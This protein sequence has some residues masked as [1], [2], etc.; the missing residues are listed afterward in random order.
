MFAMK[1]RRSV[2]PAEQPA[3]DKFSLVTTLRGAGASAT[4]LVHDISSTRFEAECLA[5]FKSGSKVR[6]NLPGL[7]DVD[8][9][10]E[11][12]RRGT[13]TAVFPQPIDLAQCVAA[14]NWADM[15]FN[16]N[17]PAPRRNFELI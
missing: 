6:I 3:R 12:V 10:V 11:A 5:R 9:R 17:A 4:V 13:L 8:A 16:D 2:Q 14:A 15:D 1:F 7:G